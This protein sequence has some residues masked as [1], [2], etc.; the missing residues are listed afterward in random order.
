VFLLPH[1][2]VLCYPRGMET[3]EKQT[4]QEEFEAAAKRSL[5]TRLKYAF[6]KTYKPVL[7]D[8]EYRSFASTAEYREWCE[9]NLP[10]WLGFRR[11]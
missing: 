8:A 11:V 2:I 1:A 9:K 7:D 3:Q 4:W 6:I 5:E 10:E